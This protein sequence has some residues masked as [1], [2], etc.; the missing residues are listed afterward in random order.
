MGRIPDTE[1]NRLKQGVSLQRLAESRGIVL[2]RHGA[3]LIG[4]CPFHDDHAPSLVISPHKN[5]WHCLGAC[6]CGGS[7]I[8][9]VMKADGV[10]FRHAV[11]LLRKDTAG[12]A[13]V[14]DDAPVVKRAT[15]RKLAAP[16]SENAD[17]QTA[18]QQVIAFYHATLKQDSE[19]QAYLKQRGLDDAEL[20]DHFKL[21]YA[22]RTLGLH[23]PQK[24]RRSGAKLRSLLQDIGLYRD[25]GHE[26][27]N[28][29]L[30]I[31]VIDDHQVR[32]VYGRKIQGGKL[33][34]GTPQHLYLPGPHA[35]VFNCDGLL[36]EEIILCESLIDALTFW[37]WGFKAVTSSFGV[38][39]F[40]DELLQCLI[41]KAIKRVLI[42]YDRDAAG[43]Q[44]AEKLAKVLNK[45]AIDANQ[46]H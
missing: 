46:W 22:N 36:G 9:W 8:D 26:H 30:V 15:V 39:G 43:N 37:R 14:A 12:M 7:V 32:E 41:D 16:L 33:R 34:K 24:N 6:Q 21:G 18:L 35:G 27:F 23:L 4:L 38:S 40:T 29:S 2:K 42:A 19:V 3:D 31:P 44:A 25:S 10:S 45:H 11:E 5:L 13:V 20:I 17:A 28:G 1:L